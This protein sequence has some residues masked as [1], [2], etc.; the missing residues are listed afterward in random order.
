MIF[1]GE[2]RKEQV[3]GVQNEGGRE[4]RI[5]VV[6][7]SNDAAAERGKRGTTRGK[8]SRNKH[9]SAGAVGS[10]VERSVRVGREGG[11]EA[12]SYTHLTLP[13]ICSV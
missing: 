12:V 1:N 10:T 6:T 11:G 9:T 2:A 5:E 7:R 4:E 3:S 8:D 13:T